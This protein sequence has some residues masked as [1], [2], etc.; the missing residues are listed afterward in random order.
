M[1]RPSDPHVELDR[2]GRCALS[3]W[4]GDPAAC[5]WCGRP[6]AEGFGWC[7]NRCGDDYRA[8][9]CW[10]LARGAA[11]GRDGHACVR[12]GLGP[13][14]LALARATLRAMVPLGPVDA[15]RLWRSAAWAELLAACSLEVHHRV[16]R[17]GAGYGAGCHHHLDGLV[18]LCHRHHAEITAAAREAG[19]A[20]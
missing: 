2:A 18:V 10:E 8:N 7:G 17:A 4:D 19:R 1:R 20:S 14:T 6:A 13:D 3:R 9:H 12:C 15:A 16:A 5:R 11:L